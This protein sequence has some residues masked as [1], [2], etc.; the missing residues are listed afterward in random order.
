M[1]AATV[2]RG[3]RIFLP[4]RVV[5]RLTDD[6]VP[7]GGQLGDD[8]LGRGD[9]AGCARGPVAAVGGGEALEGLQVGH[10]PAVVTA[11]RSAAVS[12]PLSA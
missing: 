12:V 10:D 1:V 9:V 6:V 5:E 11:P 8:V 7:G 4:G 3:W 2:E